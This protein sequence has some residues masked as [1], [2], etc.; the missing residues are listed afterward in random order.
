MLTTGLAL[1]YS[2]WQSDGRCFGNCTDL[3]YAFAI[4]QYKHCW[5][6]NLIPNPADQK[7]LSDC[8]DPCPGYPSDYCGGDGAFGYMEIGRFKPTGTAPAEGSGTKAPSSSVS[9]SPSSS[10]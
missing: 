9:R 5:C 7:S 2:D 1:V 10:S 3:K 8:Q 6:S 4:V